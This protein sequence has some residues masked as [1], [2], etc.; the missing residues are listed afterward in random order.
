MLLEDEVDSAIS[1]FH[2]PDRLVVPIWGFMLLFLGPATITIGYLA[3]YADL[4]ITTSSIIALAVMN[5]SINGVIAWLTIRL[6]GHTNDALDH[7]DAIMGGMEALDSTMAEANEMVESFTTDLEEAKNVFT[8]VGV[9]LT[10]IELEPI[11]EVVEKLKEN[12]D[13]FNEILDSL[14]D[15]DVTHYINQ[16]KR[17][18]WQSLLD[19][20]EE[21]MGFVQGRNDGTLSIPSPAVSSV[22]MPNIV[23]DIFDE[24]EEDDSF[25]RGGLT[26]APP[27]K[28]LNLTPP[29]R[30]N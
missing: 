14:K 8:K 30:S 4:G 10:G 3:L 15:I 7:L 16:A 29:R 23:N 26:L 12:K 18:D 22:P 28:N 19:S 9:D 13:G 1:R 25:F 24:D 11:A 27:P 5:G 2:E 20:A 17:I 6:D 21:I